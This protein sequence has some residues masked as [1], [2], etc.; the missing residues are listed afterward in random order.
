MIP[1]ALQGLYFLLEPIADGTFG[2][3]YLAIH[4]ITRQQV[5]I[6][7]ID[8][9]KLTVSSYNTVMNVYFRVNFIVYVAKLKLLSVYLTPIFTHYTTLLK[10]MAH[11]TL[12]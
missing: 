11:S 5:A 12:Y 2:R 3:L 9:R 4:I 7:V 6:K 10:Q 1:R 8:K